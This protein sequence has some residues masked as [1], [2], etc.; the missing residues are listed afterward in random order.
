[1]E[2]D[3]KVCVVCMGV[4]RRSGNC[5]YL[6]LEMKDTAVEVARRQINI[7]TWS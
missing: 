7:L 5:Q 1:M 3:F 6:N 4:V 2:V